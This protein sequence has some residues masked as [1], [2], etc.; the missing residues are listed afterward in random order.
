MARGGVVIDLRDQLAFGGGHM[1]GAFGIAL[2][3]LLPVWSAW[4]VPYDTPIALV[5]DHDQ[6][7]LH[8]AVL[9]ARVGLDDVAGI[10]E[11]GMKAW[12][13]SGREISELPQISAP[14]LARALASGDGGLT[15]FDVRSDREF[16]AGHVE[17]ALHQFG[18]TLED[19]LDQLPDKEAPLVVTCG[20]GYRATVI[21]SV[22]E[23]HGF[24]NLI[25]LTGG[26]GAWN[27][28]G[29]PMTTGPTSTQARAA[30]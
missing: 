19:H 10:L 6:D 29:L 5:A 28:A 14:Q 22:L 27:H 16:E 11:G 2:A 13:D 20:G 23:R 12:R 15:V 26:M 7:A 3:N 21:A 8:G 1:P 25:N 30:T 17:G 24:S 18:G 4:V 9:L